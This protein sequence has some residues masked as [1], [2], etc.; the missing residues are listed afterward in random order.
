[1]TKAR[2]IARYQAAR[3]S[4]LMPGPGTVIRVCLLGSVL[5]TAHM[6]MAQDTNT[7]SPSAADDTV[8]PGITPDLGK[9]VPTSQILAV[10]R[11]RLF[12][13][14]LYGRRI[15]AELETERSRLAM[16]ARKVE[17][18][19]A[20]EEQ[21]LTEQRSTLTPEAFRVLADAFDEKVQSLREERPVL[22]QEFKRRFETE[23]SAFFEKAGPI[24]GQVVRDRGG[25]MI[26]DRRAILLTTQKIDITDEAIRRIDE[27][28]GDGQGEPA[29]DAP[30][31]EQAEEV[32]EPSEIL[33]QID[34]PA[35][36]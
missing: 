25:V 26:I 36:N 21:S 17:A 22:E 29:L 34:P 15:L 9:P 1:M 12:T 7:E 14:S 33:P 27:I 18:A 2:L 31:G 30:A 10:D 11:D 3:W 13:G 6:A 5:G 32:I 23:R 20:E 28:L 35:Q 8:A 19:L 16:E 4:A 24:L